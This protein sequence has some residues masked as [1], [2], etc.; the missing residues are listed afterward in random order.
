[1]VHIKQYIHLK[2]WMDINVNYLIL[3]VKKISLH[4]ITSIN[5]TKFVST[6]CQPKV[7]KCQPDV[8]QMSTDDVIFM[9]YNS[10]IFLYKHAPI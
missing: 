9:Y 1:M 5:Y 3:Y 6:G 10:K 7:D 2:K 8:N 4:E